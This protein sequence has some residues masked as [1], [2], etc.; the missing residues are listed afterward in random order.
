[1]TALANALDIPDEPPRQWR[2]V[3]QG[4]VAA[5]VVLAVGVVVARTFALG[6][7]VRP[8]LA[9]EIVVGLP[10]ALVAWLLTGPHPRREWM[11]AGVVVVSL[12]L[13]PLA[14]AGATPS[15]ERLQ[16]VVNALELP[17]ETTRDVR[18]GNGRCRPSCSELRRT[19]I[20]RGTAFD[21][22]RSQLEGILRYRG[23]EVREYAYNPGE[24]LRID[25]QT[26]DYFASFELRQNTPGVTR[27]AQV[28]IARGPKS[29]NKIG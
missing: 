19:A 11:T 4:V 10:A 23:F 28:W 13:L 26:D 12:A 6:G 2:G 3:P 8:W 7:W 16:R 5:A 25:A 27:I 17:G 14:A 15:P 9:I 20:A 1:M 21:K 29:E 24:P 18:I 22:V